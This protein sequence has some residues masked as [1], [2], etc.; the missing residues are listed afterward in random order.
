MD[1]KK[2]GDAK[3]PG[4]TI[5]LV[6]EYAGI[7]GIDPAHFSLRELQWM[8]TGKMSHNW[9]WAAPLIC[10]TANVNLPKK[11][12][13]KMQDV[14]P[15]YRKPPKKPFHRNAWL[16]LKALMPGRPPKTNASTHADQHQ[17]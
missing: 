11:H 14:H 9:D 6:Y 8:A 17:S 4:W 13:L 1:G 10:W 5:R 16:Q 2:S 12:R 15:Y 3:E 7:I